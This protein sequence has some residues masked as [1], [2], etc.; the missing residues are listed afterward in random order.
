MD[1]PQQD[2]ET[3][4]SRL[5]IEAGAAVSICPGNLRTRPG[6]SHT[7]T[8]TPVMRMR[9]VHLDVA[10]PAF[11]ATTGIAKGRR[12]WNGVLDDQGAKGDADHGEDNLGKG[13]DHAVS[14][15]TFDVHN[16]RKSRRRHIPAC[17]VW[18]SAVKCSFF[19]MI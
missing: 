10:G 12:R 13:V 16:C 17:A 9:N 19:D 5:E 8:L 11:P 1:F 14:P 18:F 7:R 4:I 15:V 2:R 6:D 3:A